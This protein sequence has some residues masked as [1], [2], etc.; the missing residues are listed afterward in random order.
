MTAIAISRPSAEEYAPAFGGYVSR[1]ADV[2]DAV[3]VLARQKDRFAQSIA[4]MSDQEAGY[5]YAPEKW[6]V[7]ELVGHVC[8]VCRRMPCVDTATAAAI[9][10][11]HGPAGALQQIGGRDP[12]DPGADDD[13][14]DG[15]VLVELGEC[16][17]GRRVVPIGRSVELGHAHPLDAI[18]SKPPAM[19][20]RRA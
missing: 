11:C 7:K 20:L 12:S 18:R 2:S 6:S 10:E 1:V 3:A 16:R 5:R 4:P 8:D 17:H 9:D 15:Q 13:D 19:E 14:V